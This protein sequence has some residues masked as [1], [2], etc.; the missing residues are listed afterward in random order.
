LA[1]D[2]APLPETLI[3]PIPKFSTAGTT[4]PA[5]VAGTT[6]PAVVECRS[7]TSERPPRCVPR[8]RA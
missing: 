2:T 8:M 3:A 4:V 7:G 5:V 1:E 6:L